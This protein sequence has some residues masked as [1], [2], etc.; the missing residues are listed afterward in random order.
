MLLYI[1]RDHKDYYGQGAQDSYLDFHAQLLSSDAHSHPK[2]QH[3]KASG[4]SEEKVVD[5]K[6]RRSRCG[7]MAEGGRRSARS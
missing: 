1:H 7:M 2:T 3:L 4:E 5:G 6:E